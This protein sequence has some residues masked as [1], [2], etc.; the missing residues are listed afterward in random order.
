MVIEENQR[1][2]GDA[3]KDLTTEVK[4]VVATLQLEMSEMATIVKVMILALGNSSQEGG[5]SE[6][7]GKVKV[8]DPRSYTRE[9]DAQKL[10]NFLFDME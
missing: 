2:L 9:W 5:A 6:R 8:P 1:Q 7:R 4:D 10:E 3:I